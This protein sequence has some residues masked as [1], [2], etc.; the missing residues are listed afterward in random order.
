VSS[1]YPSN[2][3]VLQD[4]EPLTQ[5]LQTLK[6]EFGK[7]KQNQSFKIAPDLDQ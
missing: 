6:Q 3:R 1:P 2:L 5:L 4:K 7:A